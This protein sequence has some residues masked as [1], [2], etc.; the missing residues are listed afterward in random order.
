MRV[1]SSILILFLLT[2]NL[3]PA[4]ELFE[5]DQMGATCNTTCCAP[6]S[7]DESSEEEEDAC[8]D[9]CNPFLSCNS[10][11]GFMTE[12]GVV[13]LTPKEQNDQHRVDPLTEKVLQLEHSIWHP[14]KLG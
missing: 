5:S 3:L 2:L 10:C 1:S 7:S 13:I 8:S 4:L 9:N 12:N 11:H 6:A 14:P